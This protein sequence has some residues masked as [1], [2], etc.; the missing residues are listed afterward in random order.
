MPSICSAQP[1]LQCVNSF[2]FLGN[3]RFKGLKLYLIK[4]RTDSGEMHT[5]K[6]KNG[7]L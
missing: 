7:Y 6:I 5:F 2:F 3:K 1:F 4:M